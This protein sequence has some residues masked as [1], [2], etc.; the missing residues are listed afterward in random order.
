MIDTWDAK[1]ATAVVS[2]RIDEAVSSD[3]MAAMFELGPVTPL[4]ATEIWAPRLVGN[5]VA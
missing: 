2:V 3:C 5:A 1:E 4:R